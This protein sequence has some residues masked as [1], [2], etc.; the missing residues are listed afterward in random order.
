[1][2]LHHF[3]SL[4]NSQGIL[5]AG[6]IDPHCG[7]V[8]KDLPP[9]VWFTADSAR[10]SVYTGWHDD[11]VC[12]IDRAIRFTVDV[13]DGDVSQWRDWMARN[14]RGAPLVECN[15]EVAAYKAQWFVAERPIMAAEWVGW[16]WAVTMEQLFEALQ[17]VTPDSP[18]VA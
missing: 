1:M 18:Q 8:G 10:E 5:G 16:D 12:V 6:R 2:I 14:G 11:P 13:P 3:T 9:V 7:E 17:A 4:P 15:P